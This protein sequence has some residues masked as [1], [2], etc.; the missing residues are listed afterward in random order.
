[1][2]VQGTDGSGADFSS[3]TVAKV[4]RN[5]TGV[6]LPHSGRALIPPWGSPHQPV[7]DCLRLCCLVLWRSIVPGGGEYLTV[8]LCEDEEEPLIVTALCIQR[9]EQ[10]LKLVLI[11]LF[12]RSRT[13]RP[14]HWQMK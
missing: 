6:S 8:V 10:A 2:Y 3:R 1:M 4:A 12:I 9:F 13:C 14:H 11:I 5:L 7:N